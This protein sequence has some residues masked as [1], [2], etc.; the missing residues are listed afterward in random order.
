VSIK[1]SNAEKYFF[2]IGGTG[3]DI[4]VLKDALPIKKFIG[5]GA[6]FISLIKNVFTYKMMDLKL[7]VD[8][9]VEEGQ[10]VALAI[11]NGSYY[12]GHMRIAPPAVINDG[13]ITLCRIKS[14]P[15]FKMM[16]MFPLVKSGS[17]TK[18]KEVS[19]TNCS[20]VKLEFDGKKIINLDGNLSEFESP[21]TFEIMKNAVRLIV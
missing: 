20:S 10:F 15:R 13:F 19:F 9:I 7:T 21:I 5:G 4:Q 6:Y 2:N 3:I 14:M 17:H 11:C 18:L 16:T 12:G 8:G 1:S